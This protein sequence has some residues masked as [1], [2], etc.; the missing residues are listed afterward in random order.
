MCV[1]DIILKI[2][3]VIR[4]MFDHRPLVTYYTDPL[5]EYVSSLD[6][7]TIRKLNFICHN[8][9]GVFAKM[10]S[11]KFGKEAFSVGGSVFST[12]IY[13]IGIDTS[14]QQLVTNI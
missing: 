13:D 1:E 12:S 2:C 9:D 11:M 5:I 7:G 4:T 10:L 14:R 8:N 3:E 6:F